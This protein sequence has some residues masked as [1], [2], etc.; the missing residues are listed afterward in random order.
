VG[1]TWNH[2]IGDLQSILQLM[3]AWALAY[4]DQPYEGPF[5]LN[6]RTAYLAQCMPALDG[7]S[8][9][10]VASWSEW[11]RHAARFMTRGAEPLILE[12]SWA[13]LSKLQAA[14][15]RAQSVTVHDALCA[16]VFSMIHR[17]HRPDMSAIM[18]LS[19]N[20]RKRL[21][22]PAGALGNFFDG[23]KNKVSPT[24][25][26][27]AIAGAVRTHVNEF[28][29]RKPYAQELD[30]L[31][32]LN[33]QASRRLRCVDGDLDP[34]TIGTFL[35]MST[36]KGAGMY[37]LAFGASK[38][39]FY[40]VRAGDSM[41][42]FTLVVETPD[43]AGLNVQVFVPREISRRVAQEHARLRAAAFSSVNASC[44]D[45]ANATPP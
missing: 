18:M 45:T 43:A 10:F 8:S 22:M 2:A 42:W 31:H 4:R 32:A 19:M 40:C 41:C 13:E 34:R 29:R 6:D 7:P 3:R 39:V 20:Y 23:L 15:S 17:Q 30:Q 27:A 9:Q 14:A 33:R 24:D 37:E 44:N 26:V 28:P 21:G 5:N 1:I 16:H 35:T 12:F 11:P 25:D 38:P 36:H